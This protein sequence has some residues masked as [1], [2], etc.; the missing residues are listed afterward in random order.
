MPLNQA[1]TDALNL[2]KRSN[3]ILILPSSPIDG[4]SLGSALAL[5]LALKKLGKQATVVTAEE[6]ISDAY[7]FLPQVS[8]IAHEMD[9]LRDMI[10]TVDFRGNAAPDVKHEIQN[11]KLNIIITP[12][13]GSISRDNISFSRGPVPYDCVIVV[14]TADISQ[15]GKLQENFTELS[16]LAP[17]INI[18]HH[19]SN[20]MFGKINLVDVMAASTTIIILPL[21]EQLGLVDADIATL[22]LTG[23]ITDTNSFQN[24]NTT[25][26]AFAVSA[27]LIG[28]G[29]RQ[30]EIIKNIY[31]TKKLA[32]LRL[33]G[34]TLTKLQYDEAHKLVWSVLTLKDFAEIGGT[35]DDT[36]GVVD[37]LMSNAP[38]TEII[39]LLKEK[40]GGEISGSIRTL[41]PA[42]DASK[43]AALFGGGGHMQ[44]AGFKI[45]GKTVTEVEKETVERLKEF[46]KTRLG[47]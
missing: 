4:D 46:Q 3:N 14:D 1:Q 32:T 21:I 24:P 42:I 22:L 37:E 40:D 27:K 33:W 41:T 36:E 17:V 28:Y 39:L 18:D 47:I 29:A 30:Q 2:L 13:E 19:V 23:L 45:R 26:Q 20:S 16:Y 9:F 25:P 44:A 43:L 10:V 12:R 31:K 11:N 34:R 6:N 15:L 7:S 35:P 8:A 38:N 5:Y